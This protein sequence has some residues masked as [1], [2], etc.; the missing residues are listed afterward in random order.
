MTSKV[1]KAVKNSSM[2][3]DSQWTANRGCSRSPQ[4]GEADGT[5]YGNNP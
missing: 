5:N 1:V 3:F 4:S 2:N